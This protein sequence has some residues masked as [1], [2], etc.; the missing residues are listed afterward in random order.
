MGI[1]IYLQQH[2]HLYTCFVPGAVLTALY[3]KSCKVGLIIIPIAPPRKQAQKGKAVSQD[4]TSR[5]F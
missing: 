5:E 2:L 3:P 4:H 1:F